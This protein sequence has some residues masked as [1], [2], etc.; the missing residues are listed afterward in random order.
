MWCLGQSDETNDVDVPRMC[1]LSLPLSLFSLL[2]SLFSLLSSLFSLPL[3]LSSLL[4][5]L[6][7]S[8]S[9]GSEPIAL[10]LSK[11]PKSLS[12]Y[13][14]IEPFTGDVCDGE[15][16]FNASRRRLLDGT[17][18]SASRALDQSTALICEMFVCVN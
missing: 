3:P 12:G 7:P 4:S 16:L 13:V 18:L 5:P 15:T 10:V 17:G 6:S 11:K 9:T 2:S 1:N 8:L 14:T